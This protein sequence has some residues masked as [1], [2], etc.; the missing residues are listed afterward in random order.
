M[1]S[2]PRRR[3][4]TGIGEHRAQHDVGQVA[5]E[6]AQGLE[7]GLAFALALLHVGHRPRID[8]RLREGDRVKGP[9]ELPVAAPVQPMA[10]AQHSEPGVARSD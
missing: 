1:L 8:A 2:S 7:P 3:A 4:C 9:I 6:T 5:F 10:A